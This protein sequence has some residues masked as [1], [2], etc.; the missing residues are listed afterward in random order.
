MG[1][2]DFLARR[3]VASKIQQLRAELAAD[4]S[5]T[6]RRA[7]RLSREAVEAAKNLPARSR[8]RREALAM[9]SLTAQRTGEEDVSIAAAREI[10]DGVASLAEAD[11]LD[12]A[13]ANNLA[14]LLSRDGDFE[15][16]AR[17]FEASLAIKRRVLGPQ[18]PELLGSLED[19]FHCADQMDNTELA[20]RTAQ[21][22]HDIL[23]ELVSPEHPAIEVAATNIDIARRRLGLEDDPAAHEPRSPTNP[24][25]EID[26]RADEI[27]AAY[28]AM[29]SAR[30][31][32]LHASWLEERRRALPFGVPTMAD[33]LLESFDPVLRWAL[34]LDQAGVAA[35]N[36]G[37][38]SE[39]VAAF[40]QVAEV[41]QAYSRPDWQSGA[42]SNLA[43]ILTMQHD[44]PRA[45]AL[46]RE[47]LTLTESLPHTHKWRTPV[48]R[49]LA[50]LYWTMAEVEAP[51]P[52]ARL[53]VLMPAGERPEDYTVQLRFRRPMPVEGESPLS[54][55]ARQLTARSVLYESA[56]HEHRARRLLEFS[57]E[58]R[59]LECPEGDE[60]V[61]M[62]LVDLIDHDL[63][64]GHAASAESELNE[65]LSLSRELHLPSR[66]RLHLLQSRLQLLLGLNR[67]GDALGALAVLELFSE[68]DDL[69][70]DVRSLARENVAIGYLQVG[71]VAEAL[72]SVRTIL[73]EAG[74]AADASPQRLASLAQFAISAGELDRAEAWLM[75]ALEIWKEETGE[76]TA[77]Y[78]AALSNAGTVARYR[79]DWATAAQRHARAAEIRATVL[80]PQH[81]NVLKS[82]ARH[83]MDLRM[84]GRFKAAFDEAVAATSIVAR[85]LGE[86][87]TM[88][89]EKNLI[90][91]ARYFS[92]LTGLA[93]SLLVEAGPGRVAEAYGLVLRHKSIS[94]M[95]LFARRNAVLGGRYPELAPKLEELHELQTQIAAATFAGAETAYVL[96]EAELR[97]DALEAEL[98]RAI[99]EMA[100]DATMADLS[101]AK[102]AAALPPGAVLAEAVVYEPWRWERLD[103]DPSLDTITGDPRYGLFLLDGAG[104]AEFQDIGDARAIDAHVRMMNTA[105]EEGRPWI[106]PA[107]ALAAAISERVSTFARARAAER[108]YIAP[109]G[110]LSLVALDA[111]DSGDGRDV[112]EV[113]EVV[114][115]T[116]G[117]DLLRAEIPAPASPPVVVYAPDFDRVVSGPEADSDQ[118]TETPGSPKRLNVRFRPLPGTIREGEAVLR[119]FPGAVGLTGAAAT[120]RALQQVHRPAFLHLAT[121]GYFTPGDEVDEEVDPMLRSGLV[122]AGANVEDDPA[123][124]LMAAS[125]A[126]L[127]LLGTELVVLSACESGLG[128][129]AAGE[130]VFGLRRAF[131]VAGARALVMSLW[132]VRDTAT[133]DLMRL[134]YE[135][136]ATEMNKAAALRAAKL[137]LRER[138]AP[139]RDWAA[140]ILE[141]D[142]A[143][144]SP[145]A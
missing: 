71:A 107:R 80:G 126:T 22:L 135:G 50:Q 141:G 97:R 64:Y 44:F 32:A 61:L 69:E 86:A 8:E 143:P 13:A 57:L 65:A 33:M 45:K 36:A 114:F 116:T 23:L 68:E 93:L 63:K 84:L 7:L 77:A 5:Y 79:A 74:D 144:L 96:V 145:R 24:F 72:P 112:V 25:A 78:A 1:L 34:T 4:S 3:T 56:G 92:N 2:S 105:L 6:R 54:A 60:P 16:A 20:L 40:E 58:L 103:F 111:L 51:D 130:G 67:R 99:P 124:I 81:P 31:S 87:A 138:S 9:L 94:A 53:E 29:D 117:R 104:A 85:L 47:A 115:L 139:P 42:K 122:L 55:L 38:L 11:D 52:S 48:L 90:S 17:L 121:H 88:S 39:A 43:R 28:A 46:F 110:A 125:V 109:D 75:R 113:F 140:F 10:W 119:V 30:A 131:G 127:D 73:H 89:A 18:S 142:P 106:E 15:S 76:W 120:R 70:D 66:I 100:V 98:A 59:R 35:A 27:I 26:T 133:S 12:A 91:A 137:A 101:A 95:A 136:L 21:E 108:V 129:A 123:G 83:A 62:T 102:V 132:E 37:N 41:M 49:N 128:D 14:C 118:H 134:F 82:R 19:L